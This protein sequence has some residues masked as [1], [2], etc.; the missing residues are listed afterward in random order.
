MLTQAT[1]IFRKFFILGMIRP[2]LA[3][4]ILFFLYNFRKAFECI[5]FLVAFW[6]R[7]VVASYF[8]QKR[9]FVRNF[10]P[11]FFVIALS[12]LLRGTLSSYFLVLSF[13]SFATF[14]HR[15]LWSFFSNREPDA[16]EEESHIC[17]IEDFK[18]GKGIRALAYV[19]VSTERQAQH[20]FSV[21]AQVDELR[22]L[23]KR[24][25]ASRFYLITDAG[26]SGVDFDKRNL[27]K[28]LELAARK[29]ID[30]VLVVDVDRIGRNCRKL[31]EFFL[32]LR[33]HGVV[34]V[35]PAG[36]MDIEE[37]TGLMML[38]LRSWAAQFENERR[39][40][41]SMAGRVQ[42]FLTGRW[43]KPVPKGYRKKG[44]WIEKDPA[45]APITKDV[46]S[47][48]QRYKKYRPV[49]DSVNAKYTGSLSQ[50]LTRQQVAEILRNPV[51]VGRPGYYGKAVKKQFRDN[52]FVDAPSLAYVSLETFGTTQEIVNEIRRT[53]RRR[54]RVRHM[55][56]IG[57]H[58]YDVLQ[59]MPHVAIICPRSDCGNPMN[60]NGLVDHGSV[61]NFICPKCGKQLRVPKKSELKEIEKWV[62]KKRRLSKSEVTNPSK[63]S[64][65]RNR[66]L[67]KQRLDEVEKSASLDNYACIG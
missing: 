24:R 15:D 46:F 5:I 47:F 25:G 61:N 12:F 55:E 45:W 64:S 2:A 32:D 22:A 1:S 56:L 50:R 42:A 53:Y 28:I 58:D 27:N 6:H 23:A 60:Y 30:E 20:G 57:K 19:R 29:E 21:E 38:A 41:A 51:Y 10:L 37:L 7:R 8:F 13:L 59:F 65:N 54:K 17:R 34:I 66:S 44:D 14:A 26:K 35:T 67:R 9:P 11:H 36:Q 3:E 52:V 31:M 16:R 18:D 49:A 33:D 62:S 43:N 39:A 40:R 63:A 48:F 4:R